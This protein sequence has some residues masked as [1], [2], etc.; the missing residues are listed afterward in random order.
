MK[1][2]RAL[3]LERNLKNSWI[4]GLFCCVM[5][6]SGELALA[7]F[8]LALGLSVTSVGLIPTLPMLA[9][10][11]LA[12]FASRGVRA[13]RSMRRFVVATAAIQAGAFLPLALG[14]WYGSFPA[15]G[16]F[17]AATLYWTMG[18]ACGAGWNTWITTLVPRPIRAHYFG[19]RSRA[20]QFTQGAAL[21]GAG[22]LLEASERRGAE[23]AGFGLVFSVACAARLVSAAFLARHDEPQPLPLGFRLLP[24]AEIW[25]SL[26]RRT[27]G[28]LIGCLFALQFS[29]QLATPYCAPYLRRALQLDYAPF[30]ALLATLFLGKLLGLA[31]FAR[32]ARRHGSVALLRLAALALVP[33]ALPWIVSSAPWALF[34]GQLATGVATGALELSIYLA[35][36]DHAEASERASVL[37]I[38]GVTNALAFTLGAV[39]GAGLLE[40]LGTR[41][42]SY[43]IL[44]AVSCALRVL[45]PWLLTSWLVRPLDPGGPEP[46]P[47]LL[48]KTL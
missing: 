31:W 45:A 10:A 18:L 8:G 26:T 48:G 14:A 15:W 28:R 27:W 6:G 17:L 22:L 25:R 42:D 2:T 1:H 12:L 21:V 13:L 34:T 23:L 5:V 33:S 43:R 32:Y 7:A 47:N 20:L 16:L 37:S 11:L 40:F 46:E 44:F 35:F 38:Y 39:A 24:R 19:R 3:A 36:F 9:G 29:M 41:P 4:D 30:M